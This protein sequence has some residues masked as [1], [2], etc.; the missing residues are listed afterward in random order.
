MH[1]QIPGL[2]FTS[3][4]FAVI[5]TRENDI[6][7]KL[8]QR[9]LSEYFKYVIWEKTETLFKMGDVQISIK[10]DSDYPGW[11]P[12]FQSKL[13]G[14]C[15]ES[16]KELFKEDI[17]IK[18]IHAGLECGIIKK[19]FPQM[20]MISIGPTT[21]GAHSPDEKLSIKSAEKVWKLL[22]NLLGK[23]S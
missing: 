15:K 20:E 10:R 18:A 13:L 19:K 23:I 5:T 8:S 2:V 1:P 22:L 21:E 3:S 12:N 7:I 9:S 6:Q 11:T 16:Y 14:Y 17:N 4:N